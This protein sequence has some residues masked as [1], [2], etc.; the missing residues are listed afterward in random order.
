MSSPNLLKIST[1]LAG[2]FGIYSIFS[3]SWSVRE[4]SS[5]SATLRPGDVSSDS[6]PR[7][8]SLP[9]GRGSA[10]RFSTTGSARPYRL[11]LPMPPG[12]RETSRGGRRK[13]RGRKGGQKGGQFPLVM[14]SSLPLW[15]SSADSDWPSALALCPEGKTVELT[16]KFI[17]SSGVWGC[18]GGCVSV[19]KKRDQKK[20][21]QARIPPRCIHMDIFGK[22]L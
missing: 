20:K 21:I 13:P 10:P 4:V 18:V 9:P 6:E 5:F 14:R 8:T 16:D 1:N 22:Y 15:N 3:P 11:V 12:Q 17:Y 2:P 7:R 19:K